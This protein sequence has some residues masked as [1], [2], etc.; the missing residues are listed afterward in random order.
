MHTFY[1][2]GPD[3]GGKGHYVLIAD[4]G[5]YLGGHWCSHAGFAQWDLVDRRIQSRQ[6]WAERFGDYQVVYLGKDEMTSEELTRRNRAWSRDT[7]FLD[8]QPGASSA[9]EQQ[10]DGGA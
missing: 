8:Q 5:E 9:A 4:T 6:E 7:T 1:I 3:D 2:D 10:G